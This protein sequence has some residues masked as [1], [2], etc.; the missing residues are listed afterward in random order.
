[1]LNENPS[2]NQN[3]HTDFESFYDHAPIAYL[4][5]DREKNIHEINAAAAEILGINKNVAIGKNIISFLDG[6][7]KKYFSELFIKSFEKK[8]KIAFF[9]QQVLT[10]LIFSQH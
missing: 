3:E 6:N 9:K 10:H 8:E 2:L 7:D 4:A 5:L 1:M